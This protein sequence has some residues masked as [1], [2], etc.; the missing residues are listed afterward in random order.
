M[1]TSQ[2]DSTGPSPALRRQFI[3]HLEESPTLMTLATV[4]SDGYP[5]T[6]N[7]QVTGVGEDGRVLFHT[8]T[9]SQKIRDIEACPKASLTVITPD[10][11][12]QVTVIGDVVRDTPEGERLAFTRRSRYLQLLAWLNDTG[13][14]LQD[15]DERHRI[16]AEFDRTHPDLAEQDPPETWIGYAVVPR[17]YLFWNGDDN[18]PSRRVHYT[19]AD[20]GSDHWTREIL[21]G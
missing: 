7:V 19:R 3:D 13:L 14:A 16:W 15:V 12:R 20:T 2:S 1:T 21:P 18:G 4:S 5:R 9:R 6:R 8:D 10:K 11:T 17:E